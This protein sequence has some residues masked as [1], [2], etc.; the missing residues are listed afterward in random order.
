MGRSKKDEDI[1]QRICQGG[2]ARS[3]DQVSAPQ[4]PNHA[5]RPRSHA[6]NSAK[7][8]SSESQTT[9]NGIEAT[10]NHTKPADGAGE[11]TQKFAEVTQMTHQTTQR[12]GRNHNRSC[13]TTQIT[14]QATR[15]MGGAAEKWTE[16]IGKFG[17]V[18]GEGGRLRDLD[19][20]L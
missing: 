6:G 10:R 8:R 5:D 3:P 1:A 18:G 4:S 15:G 13:E 11:T 17:R 19:K 7:P 2:A 16:V 14:V 9:Q 20:F 12:T